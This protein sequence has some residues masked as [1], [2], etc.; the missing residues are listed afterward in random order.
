MT[1]EEKQQDRTVQK[2]MMADGRKDEPTLVSC[3]GFPILVFLGGPVH[4]L[5]L[6]VECPG[7]LLQRSGSSDGGEH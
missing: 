7:I 6:L 5:L 1:S 4:V 3:D 2:L